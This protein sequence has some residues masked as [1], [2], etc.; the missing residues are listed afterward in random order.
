MEKTGVHTDTGISRRHKRKQSVEREKEKM[1]GDVGGWGWVGWDVC[2][3]VCVI[4]T[5]GKINAL[6]LVCDKESLPFKK[7]TPASYLVT[8]VTSQLYDVAVLRR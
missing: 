5:K 6:S 3:C 2:V 7:S 1:S 8:N 4:G